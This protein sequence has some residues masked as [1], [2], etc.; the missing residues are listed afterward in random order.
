MNM[1][2][3]REDLVSQFDLSQFSGDLKKVVAGYIS[4]GYLKSQADVDSYADI[5]LNASKL[6][7][8]ADQD[9]RVYIIEQCQS[10]F[11][12]T[13]DLY[14]DPEDLFGMKTVVANQL[15]KEVT[16]KEKNNTIR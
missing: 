11:G 8:S 12:I 1:Y 4:K 13:L 3:I 14:N 5:V 9:D 7:T 2:E 15:I 10:R 16:E 6:G